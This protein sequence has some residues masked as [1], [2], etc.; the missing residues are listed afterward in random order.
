VNSFLNGWKAIP[1]ANL[2]SLDS[3]DWL[4][5]TS[6]R[7]KTIGDER[8]KPTGVD[9]GNSETGDIVDANL[10]V[11]QARNNAKANVKLEDDQENPAQN[12]PGKDD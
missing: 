5:F 4:N 10:S 7:L 9:L 3:R 8:A 11:Q 1:G 6:D 2:R 12:L